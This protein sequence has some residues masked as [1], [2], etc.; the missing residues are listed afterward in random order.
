MA[1]GA[2]SK[3]LVEIITGREFENG[4]QGSIRGKIKIW[5]MK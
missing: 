3:V 2:V 5:Q 4:P 1:R